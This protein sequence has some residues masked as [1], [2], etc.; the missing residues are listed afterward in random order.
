M[1]DAYTNALLLR[2]LTFEYRC[3]R[4]ISNTILSIQLQR[5][6]HGATLFNFKII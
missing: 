1:T 5:T 2:G 3:M 4:R 6:I